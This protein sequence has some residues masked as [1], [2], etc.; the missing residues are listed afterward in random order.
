MKSDSFTRWRRLFAGVI[1]GAALALTGCSAGTV[2]KV[3][4]KI[5][6]PVTK[7]TTTVQAA[8]ATDLSQIPAYSGN[9]YVA[10]N[11]NKPNFTDSDL[12][13]SS[14]E[15]YS[16][17]DSLGRCGVAM[18]CVGKDTMPKAGEQRGSISSIT[19]TGWHNARYDFVDGKMVYNRCHLI[20][21][22]LTDENA[23][24][25]N[26]IT[27]TRTLNIDGMLPFENMVT[28]YIKETGNH[29]LYRVT[30]IF[31]GNELVARGVQMEGE[32]VEDKGQGVLFNVYCYNVEPGVTIDYA[33]GYTQADG[34][35]GSAST[36]GSTA[37]SN[38]TAASTASTAS[39][40][41]TVQT[42]VINTNNHKFHKPDC[43]AVAHMADKNKQTVN[44]KRSDLI[45]QGYTACGICKP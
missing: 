26:L 45:S 44:A 3:K 33:T 31:Q 2:N 28:D 12:T 4:S 10:L 40:D 13:T 36:S 5:K 24:A 27:G 1:L 25:K 18:A 20:A 16:D 11:N 38:S 42:Y 30:P 17:L 9:P 14:Y 43:S 34:T 41:D 19:P 37:S 29:V 39:Q 6:N 21:H 7:K 15:H 35:K 32:S 8:T 22:E 23:N